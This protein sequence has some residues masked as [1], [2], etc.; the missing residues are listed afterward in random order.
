MVVWVRQ[1]EASFCANASPAVGYNEATPSILGEEGESR[2]LVPASRDTEREMTM[3]TRRRRPANKGKKCVRRKKVP[4]IFGGK[5]TRCASFGAGRRLRRKSHHAGAR[6]C[7]KGVVKSGP[8]KGLCR[9]VRVRR[10][11]RR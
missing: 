5:V 3:A 1:A 10:Y 6:R 8:R 2:G 4:S 9:K 11:R 7:K